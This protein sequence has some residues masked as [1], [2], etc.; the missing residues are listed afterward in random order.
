A[1][2]QT[3]PLLVAAPADAAPAQAAPRVVNGE[4]GSTAEWPFLV[5]LAR[6]STFETQG[7]LTAQFCGGTLASETLVITAAHCVRGRKAADLVVGSPGPSGALSSL[8]LRVRNVT[9][10]EVSPGYDP[11]TFAGDIA[12]I[13]L[14]L[15]LESTPTL[16]PATA[17]EAR[18]LAAARKTVRVA[19]WGATN[20]T[21]PW[22]FPDIFRTGSLTVFPKS[23]C[24]GGQDFVLDGI[25]FSGYGP[26]DVDPAAMLCADGV[27]N[28]RPVDA[29]VGDSGGPLVGGTGDG[30]RLVGVVSWGI[31]VCGSPRGPGVYARV[32]AYNEFLAAAGVP[33]D[34][35]PVDRPEPPEVLRVNTSPTSLT[36]VV[37]GSSEGPAPDAYAV[38]AVAPD[39][40][41]LECTVPAP[42]L[43]QRARCTVE[44]LATGT[45]YVVTARS[46]IGT[47]A[48]DPSVPVEVLVDGLPARPR[49]QEHAVQPGGTATFRIVNMRGNGSPLVT[50]V[51]ECTA[52]GRP[53]R[54]GDIAAG[55]RA[56]VERLR[57]GTEYSCV[58][59][60]AN[61][62]GASRSKAV[63]LVAR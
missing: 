26:A 62:Y 43:P 58:A 52:A 51:V 40:S 29:C 23:S 31:E 11:Q 44:G 21:E 41:A 57:R 36:A 60:V 56:T 47:A 38:T 6:K 4:Q 8:T 22:K 46:L 5:A 28:G 24:G 14:D 17:E 25:T 12:V 33:F 16:A 49:I 7:F 35:D 61:E 48:S 39:G 2:L 59:I 10:I 42:A 34:N 27:R 18:T 3:L 53:T 63:L 54:S 1:A 45:T 37:R 55:G 9:R 13:T 32:S 15:P 20:K 30:R 19:G 50:K